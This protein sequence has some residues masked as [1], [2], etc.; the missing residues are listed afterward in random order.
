MAEKTIEELVSAFNTLRSEID[1]VMHDL[2]VSDRAAWVDLVNA[3]MKDVPVARPESLPM[4]NGRPVQG[5]SLLDANGKVRDQFREIVAGVY[6]HEDAS[7]NVEQQPV[8]HNIDT[9]EVS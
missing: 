3:N 5:L 6:F 7:W 4:I 1:T 8:T 9:P 2:W